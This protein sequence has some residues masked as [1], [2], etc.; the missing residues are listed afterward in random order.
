MIDAVEAKATRVS[1]L[2]AVTPGGVLMHIGLQHWT[3][4]IDIR[5]LTLAEVTLLGTDTYT[6]ADLRATVAALHEGAYGTLEWMETRPM[7]DGPQAFSDL[8]KGLMAPSKV[9]LVPAQ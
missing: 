9:V 7:S 8:D 6:M 4:E 2:A 3:S 1:A 5:K